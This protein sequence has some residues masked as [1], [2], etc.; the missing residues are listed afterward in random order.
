[1]KKI[2][3]AID[4]L[5]ATNRIID[6]TV[7]IASK[8]NSKVCLVHSQP[9]NTYV[10]ATEPEYY[11]QVS[12]EMLEAHKKMVKTHMKK[13]KSIFN[14]KNINCESTIMEGPT[15]KNIR[16]EMKKFDADLVILGSHKHG[17]FYHFIFGTVHDSL[18]NKTDTPIL[19]IPPLDEK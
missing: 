14:S 15:V 16:E 8:F 7:K 18:I 19:V 6:Y 12:I 17:K 9:L 1:M 2:L 13:I 4:L 11:E 5:E 10:G 3:V